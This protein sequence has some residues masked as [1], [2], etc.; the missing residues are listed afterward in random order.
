MSIWDFD[1]TTYVV[2]L[3]DEAK[4]PN[5][6]GYTVRDGWMDEAARIVRSGRK[7]T[8][9]FAWLGS[10]GG[11]SVLDCEAKKWAGV[12]PADY[13]AW[14][15]MGVALRD[16]LPSW[17]SASGDGGAGICNVY[18]PIGRVELAARLGF[19][20][21]K[22]HPFSGTRGASGELLCGDGVCLPESVVQGR[23]VA[24]HTEPR[25]DMR[26]G[27]TGMLEDVLAVLRG[28]LAPVGRGDD[29][30]PGS[31]RASDAPVYTEIARALAFGT[32]EDA[33]AVTIDVVGSGGSRHYA[34]KTWAGYA[35]AGGHRDVGV[36]CDWILAAWARDTGFV[37][38]D[39]SKAVNDEFMFASGR[40]NVQ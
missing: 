37:M 9:G 30:P 16:V 8:G 17:V 33:V 11:W 35:Y 40:R 6:T 29:G 7:V 4:V 13:P 19:P 39:V 15:Q 18:L 24:W 2:P 1:G 38:R 10:G 5:W 14:L 21:R 27:W 22:K 25:P 34:C 31:G 26:E 20:V 28:S 23:L 3:F 12:P 32:F 36:V